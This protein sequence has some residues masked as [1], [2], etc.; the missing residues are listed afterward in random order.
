MAPQTPPDVAGSAWWR[1]AASLAELPS[2][3]AGFAPPRR[4]ATRFVAR[5]PQRQLCHAQ[6]VAEANRRD[7]AVPLRQRR[8]ERQADGAAVALVAGKPRA[9]PAGAPARESHVV[10][11]QAAR[12]LPAAP[13]VLGQCNRERAALRHCQ[14]DNRRVNASGPSRRGTLWLAPCSGMRCLSYRAPQAHGVGKVFYLSK[15]RSCRR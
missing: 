10:G 5:Q 7:M 14:H 1:P 3:A 15:E 11:K 13:G 9:L 12:R 6:P 4:C 8:L 2:Q